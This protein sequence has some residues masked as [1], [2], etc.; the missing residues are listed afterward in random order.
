[1]PFLQV[2]KLE[3]TVFAF[4]YTTRETVMT[5]DQSLTLCAK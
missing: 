2:V 3:P 1:M 4:A 5:R